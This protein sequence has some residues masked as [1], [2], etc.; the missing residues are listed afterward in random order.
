MWPDEGPYLRA[1]NASAA[2]A[3]RVANDKT[4]NADTHIGRRPKSG[5]SYWHAVTAEINKASVE[6]DEKMP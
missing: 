3:K 1:A 2:Y 4:R 5:G 6:T